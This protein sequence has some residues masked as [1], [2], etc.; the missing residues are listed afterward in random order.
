MVRVLV[1]AFPDHNVINDVI[2]AGRWPL[3]VQTYRFHGC[4]HML[5]NSGSR[6]LETEEPVEAEKWK[7][8]TQWKQ[9]NGN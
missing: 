6:E 4:T 2:Q 9:R 5:L 8:R 3:E 7:L 1:L